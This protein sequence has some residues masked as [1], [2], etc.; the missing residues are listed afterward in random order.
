MKIRISLQKFSNSFVLALCIHL[1]IAVII[2]HKFS[3]KE[4]PYTEATDKNFITFELGNL[5]FKNSSENNLNLKSNRTHQ[6]KTTATKTTLSPNGRVTNNETNLSIPTNDSAISNA[7]SETSTI[8]E[9]FGAGSETGFSGSIS[10]TNSE[11]IFQ[12]VV[13]YYKNPI[14]PSIAIKRNIQGTAIVKINIFA[15]GEIQSFDFLQSTGHQLL[16]T[17]ISDAIKN[18]KFKAHPKGVNYFVKKTIVFVL[19]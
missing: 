9:G 19:K 17:S 16:D 1:V 18:W 8:S 12:G 15:N 7:Q 6:K 14:Y 13:T 4:I 5:Q 3:S 2:S 10:G 11:G